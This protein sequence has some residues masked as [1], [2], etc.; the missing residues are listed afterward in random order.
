M[1]KNPPRG[2]RYHTP[3]LS[4]GRSLSNGSIEFLCEEGFRK[5]ICVG[6]FSTFLTSYD[7]ETSREKKIEIHH[8]PI[9]MDEFSNKYDF[10]NQVSRA[11]KFINDIGPGSKAYLFD[12]GESPSAVLLVCACLRVL[13]GWSTGDAL[14]EM[15]IFQDGIPNPRILNLVLDSQKLN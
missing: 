10:E 8:Y 1:S 3:D 14:Y 15:L 6:D 2:F 13:S 4:L 11:V 12:N 5:F 7:R 9:D